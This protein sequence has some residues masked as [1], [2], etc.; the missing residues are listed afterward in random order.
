MLTINSFSYTTVLGLDHISWIYSYLTES[1]KQY[2]PGT[3]FILN[4]LKSLAKTSHSQNPAILPQ[5]DHY[6]IVVAVLILVY[7]VIFFNL[8]SY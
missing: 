8:K 4:I 7:N 3:R 1:Y 5:H 6:S 2:V